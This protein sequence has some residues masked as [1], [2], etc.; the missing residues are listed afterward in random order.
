MT[1]KKKDQLI[2]G[3]GHVARTG[4]DTA[5]LA[6]CRDLQFVRKGFADQL[7]ELALVADPLVTSATRTVNTNI[8]HGHLAWVVQGLGGWEPAKDNYPEVR[9]FLQR[10]GDGG[11]T[12][13]GEDFWIDQLMRSI[14]SEPRVV[15]PDVRYPNEAEAIKAAGGV[16]I[17]INRPGV[18][19]GGHV[20]ETALAGWTGW[21]EEFTNGSDIQTLQ[22]N[23]VAYVRNLIEVAK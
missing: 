1:V 14:Q 5:A 3:I 11:R 6:L 10:L 20:S 4:K 21:D 23:V 7:K 18:V 19:G 17:R 9:K 16:V 8:G 15:I 12:V 2:V 13:F 22:S